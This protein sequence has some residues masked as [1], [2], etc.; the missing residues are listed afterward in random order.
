M[1]VVTDKRLSKMKPVKT[2]LEALDSQGVGYKLYDDVRVEPTDI[3]YVTLFPSLNVKYI[4]NTPVSFN[5][6]LAEVETVFQVCCD[7]LVQTLGMIMCALFSF[8]WTYS[9]SM[10]HTEMAMV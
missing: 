5:S 9:F 10:L 2:V 7:T 4:Y 6:I 8:I 1:M 3:R